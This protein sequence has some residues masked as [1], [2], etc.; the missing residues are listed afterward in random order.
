MKGRTDERELVPPLKYF[1][2][3]WLGFSAV[4]FLLSC[5]VFSGHAG[6]WVTTGDLRLRLYDGSTIVNTR[7][8][9]QEPDDERY[10]SSSRARFGLRAELAPQITVVAMGQAWNRWAMDDNHWRFG[11]G[12]AYLSLENIAYI[13][14]SL[15]A[16]RHSSHYGSGLIFDGTD[17]A[18][19]YDGGVL[20]YDAEP[21][22]VDLEVNRVAAGE[23]STDVDYFAWLC[24][25]YRLRELADAKLAAYAGFFS[26]S[27]EAR[28]CLLGWRLGSDSRRGW[29]LSVEG[30]VEV[31]QG[32]DDGA[33]LAWI[34]DL[35]ITRNLLAVE[36]PPTLSLRGTYAS[37]SDEVGGRHD[38]I[39][40]F[41]GQDWGRV[42]SPA[43]ADI[44]I[45]ALRLAWPVGDVVVLSLDGFGYWQE[46]LSVRS[47]A[48]K[49][50]ESGGYGL[51][52]DGDNRC[53][54]YETDLGGKLLIN[55]YLDFSLHGGLFWPGSAYADG[56]PR[57]GLLMVEVQGRF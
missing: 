22:R 2:R 47:M 6:E 54:G 46:R 36:K 8:A 3:P 7:S 24:G 16:G 41:N 33:L 45:L 38:F 31:G 43:L 26:E 48:D 21:Y 5:S 55:E 44:E 17:E 23:F 13:P 29:D 20:S 18:W 56:S 25:Q 52:T 9:S 4:V 12:P 27:T 37:G 19:L 57:A 28:P 35:V 32:V 10:F 50:F 15:C 14:L 34:A 40:L 49:R 53:L 30:A 39:P 51:M 42:Y 11:A 1:I